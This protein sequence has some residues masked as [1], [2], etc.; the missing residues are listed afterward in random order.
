[1][2]KYLL[3]IITIAFLF[4]CTNVS[5]TSTEVSTGSISGNIYN[6]SLELVIDTLQIKLFLKNEQEIEVVIDSLNINDGIF[7]FKNLSEGNY[8][9]K[10][11]K[12]FNEI[13]KKEGIYLSNGEDKEDVNI[14]I[15]IMN[16]DF[17]KG[18]NSWYIVEDGAGKGEISIN[19]GELHLSVENCGK[20][21]SDLSIRQKYIQLYKGMKYELS[22]DAYSTEVRE[23]KASFKQPAFPFSWLGWY[24][25]EGTVKIGTVKK[26]YSSE[27]TM[28]SPD[29]DNAELTFDC[30]GPYT[31][32]IFIDNVILK[33]VEI[34]TQIII[35]TTLYLIGENL[36]KNGDFL[37][38]IQNWD[39]YGD[40]ETTFI[41]GACKLSLSSSSG[42]FWDVSLLQTGIPLIEGYEY[43]LQ[44][45]ASSEIAKYIEILVSSSTFPWVKYS[46]YGALGIAAI[47]NNNNRYT[48]RFTM[49][50][51][52]DFNSQL[53]F[54]CGIDLTELTIS[55]V[56][57]TLVSK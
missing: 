13:G 23:I 26:K 47:D 41:N 42:N 45:N 53:T 30:G 10:A 3:S 5:G 34:D 28:T 29:Y 18:T 44:F 19:N 22:F 43:E 31:G 15:E 38:S 36:I 8:T 40:A 52:T 4:K 57:L 27:F 17:N 12:R 11:Y 35:D 32:D 20:N 48:K 56:V 9:V 16:G 7:Y 50:H 39:I 6:S 1:M 54:N 49:N 51:L 24:G 25:A 46:W 37:D 21:I 33:Q 55:D 2:I 14:R